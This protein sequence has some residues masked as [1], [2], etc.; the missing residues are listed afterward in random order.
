M[1][2]GALS[3]AARADDQNFFAGIYFQVEVVK[4]GFSLAEV[5]KGEILKFDDG[6]QAHDGACVLRQFPEWMTADK[7]QTQP[8]R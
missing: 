3:T 7:A 4:G 1:P 6:W 2:N 8:G 5:L